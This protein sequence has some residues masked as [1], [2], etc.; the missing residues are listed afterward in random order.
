M[1]RRRVWNEAARAAFMKTVER[2][3]SREGAEELRDAARAKPVPARGWPRLVSYYRLGC[4][5]GIVSISCALRAKVCPR[6]RQRRSR[7][8]PS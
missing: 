2:R 8:M 3:Q 7:T 6:R 5:A 1:K 4:A